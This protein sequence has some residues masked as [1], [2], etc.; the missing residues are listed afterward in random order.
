M[1]PASDFELL[2][3]VGIGFDA[4]TRRR[5]DLGQDDLALILRMLVQEPAECLELVR[6]ALGV[7]ETIDADDAGDR[8]PALH[9]AAG[10]LGL[11]E[12]RHVDA[13]RKARNRHEAVE[14]PYAAV[15][16]DAAEDAVGHVVEEIGNVRSR[17]DADEIV[18]GECPRQRL[19]F[20]D[21][22]E[23]LPGRAGDVQIEADRVLHPELPELGGERDQVIV[24][25]PDHVVWAQQRL[26]QRGEALVDRNEAIEEAG[27]EL[28]KVQSIVKDRP[29][30]GVG[31][32][33]IVALVI[34]LG[35]R[36]GGE[37]TLA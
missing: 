2:A 15:R 9:E 32:A 4:G 6:Q 11:G 26:Q 35:E 31:I 16:H 5:G 20:R 10:A 13:D 36:N 1:E 28:G 21:G 30:H 22:Q 25:D 27:L 14:Q 33:Q 8:R 24:V 23:G 12:I 19:M 7:V 34:A 18:G 29:E 17:L 3:D 37:A